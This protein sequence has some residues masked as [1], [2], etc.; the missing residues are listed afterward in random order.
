MA[1]RPNEFALT[2][3]F[4]F[5]ALREANNYRKALIREFKAHLRGRVLE[6]GAGIGQMTRMIADLPEVDDILGIEPD[7][8]FCDEFKRQVPQLQLLRCTA[9]ALKADSEWNAIVSINVLEHIEADQKELTHYRKLL[10]KRGGRLCLFV[11]ARPEIYAP[12]DKDFGHFRRYTKPELR[13][14][15]EQA[16]FKIHRLQYF[17]I[18]GYF[19]WWFQFTL[20]KQRKFEIGSVRTFDRYIFPVTNGVESLLPAPPF[21][22]SL[23]AVAE[24]GVPK[25]SVKQ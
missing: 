5:D 15:L 21:G 8:D 9:E 1:S 23:I 10:S 3:N 24:A 14:K 13:G 22:Q 20:R 16:G 11:P 18:T 4:E 12:I 7:A 19:A 17:N 25:Q 2:N 6:V